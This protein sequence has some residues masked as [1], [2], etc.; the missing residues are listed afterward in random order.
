MTH[1]FED[2][3]TSVCLQLG[4]QGGKINVFVF[5]FKFKQ[6]LSHN[7]SGLLVFC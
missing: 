1:G 7:V 6:L 3:L 2:K 4:K 5:P